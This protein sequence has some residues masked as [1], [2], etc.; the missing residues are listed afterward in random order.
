MVLWQ[1]IPFLAA[2]RIRPAVQQSL[3]NKYYRQL[4]GIGIEAEHN[5]TVALWRRES[6]TRCQRNSDFIW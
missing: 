3:S 6:P 4:A 5:R 1:I 2:L